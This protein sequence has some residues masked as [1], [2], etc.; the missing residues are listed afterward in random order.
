MP[1]FIQAINDKDITDVEKEG[2]TFSTLR[3]AFTN[4]PV[5]AFSCKEEAKNIGWSQEVV[6]L[7]ARKATLSK[8]NQIRRQGHPPRCGFNISSVAFV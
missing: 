2:Q 6:V 1:D 7:T 4:V 5:G 8:S 3:A